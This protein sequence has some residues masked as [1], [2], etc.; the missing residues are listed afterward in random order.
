MF[1]KQ[2]LRKEFDQRLIDLMTEIKKDWDQQQE[3][4]RLSYER[5]DELAY[6]TSLA[7]AKF[8]F[9]LQE[10]KQRNISKKSP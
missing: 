8:I 6:R 9:L 2:K 7:K 1:R 3:I 5:D 10:A 4:L